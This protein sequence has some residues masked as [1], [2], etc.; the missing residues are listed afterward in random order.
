MASP[1]IGLT[2]QALRRRIAR[3]Y[4]DD[5][6]GTATTVTAGSG[7]TNGTMTAVGDLEKY[8]ATPSNLVGGELSIV[9]GLGS[10][11]SKPITAHSYA[12]PT[13]TLTI[14]GTWTAGDS[15]STYEI[16]RKFTKAQYDDAINNAVDF[17]ADSYFTDTFSIPWAIERANTLAQDR[18]EYPIPSGFNYI[19]GVD[20]LDISATTK[21]DLSKFDVYR[22]MGDATAR[23]EIAQGFKVSTTG[24]YQWVVIP[25][26]EVGTVTDNLVLEIQTD[27]TGPSGT[28]VTYGTSDSVTGSGLDE[29]FRNVVFKF[30]PPV[31]LTGGTQYHL[32]ITRSGSVSSTNYYR[33]GEDDD[34]GYGDGTLYTSDATTY[35]A[36]TGSD[37][38]FAIFRA[39]DRW[40]PFKQRRSGVVGWEYRRVGEDQIFLPALPSDMTPIRIRGLAAIAETTTETAT[41]P[42]RPE[43]VEAFA[44]QY[45]AASRAGRALPDNYAQQAAL[46]ADVIMRRPKPIRH[47]PANSIRVFA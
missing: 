20:Y 27:S 35:T 28:I 32:V 8:P 43:W 15:T 42:I 26:L 41:I 29:A 37:L 4:D 40:I 7:G 31:F 16:H 9:T 23:T 39:S 12:D 30:D 46:W 33:V 3:R 14:A 25:M 45:L 36:V 44:V 1:T 34:N 10:I 47:L 38:C 21:H 6:Q 5:I 13:T 19:Y 22:A 2:L 11:Q 24:F 18:H 17:L